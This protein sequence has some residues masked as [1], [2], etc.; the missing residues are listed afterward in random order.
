MGSAAGG[1]AA[2]AV[3][4]GEASGTAAMPIDVDQPPALLQITAVPVVTVPMH[5]LN[6][7]QALVITT[8]GNL[9]C[10]RKYLDKLPCWVP[11]S[12]IAR[13]FDKSTD[14]IQKILSH[15]GNVPFLWATE[16]EFER[17]TWTFT[18][19]I[20]HMHNRTHAS[21]MQYFTYQK[22]NCIRKHGDAHWQRC[23]GQILWQALLARYKDPYLRWLLVHTHPH[24]LISM[25]PTK[26]VENTPGITNLFQDLLMRLRG[27]IVQGLPDQ[28]YPK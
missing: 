21:A 14:D 17:L 2:G 7:H 22:T 16:F 1:S 18:E 24:P 3:A 4:V 28:E 10:L 8:H 11:S 15:N 20:V 6:E 27:H 23:K 26:I 25:N 13:A 9:T 12:E 5:W 19:P